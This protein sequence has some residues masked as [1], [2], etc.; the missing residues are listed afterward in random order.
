MKSKEY[1]Q[2]YFD[3]M[4]ENNLHFVIL[5]NFKTLSYTECMRKLREWDEKEG[6]AINIKDLDLTELNI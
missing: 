3:Y 2:F 6:N 5:P 4:F 1:Y